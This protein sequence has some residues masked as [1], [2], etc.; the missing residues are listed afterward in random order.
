MRKPPIMSVKIIAKNRKAHFNYEITDT[1]EAGVALLGTEVK[2]L[3]LGKLNLSDSFAVLM[4]GELYWLNANIPVYSH[5]NQFNHDP[6]R[7]RKLLVHK[8]QLR[9]LIGAIREKGVTLIPLA[10]YWKE[11]RVK[12]EFG[13]GRGKKL[14]DKRETIKERDWQREKERLMKHG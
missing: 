7:T 13:L 5:G 4:D 3:R 6:F 14:Y 12:L 1:M 11:G 9:T 10:C 8:Q 2:S